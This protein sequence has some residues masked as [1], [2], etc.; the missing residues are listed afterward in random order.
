MALSIVS[1]FIRRCG[2]RVYDTESVGKGCIGL[3]IA[4]S[5]L[6]LRTAHARG[7]ALRLFTN[8][9]VLRF[10]IESTVSFAMTSQ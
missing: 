1:V 3:V 8:S 5:A 2:N 6:S 9:S 7:V 4:F 10:R